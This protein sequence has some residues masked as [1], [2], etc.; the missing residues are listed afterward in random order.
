MTNQGEN[1]MYFKVYN[2]DPDKAAPLDQRS[3][4]SPSELLARIETLGRCTRWPG[5]R[6]KTSR[7]MGRKSASTS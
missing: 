5:S 6:P 3:K 7:S 2:I 4:I 1:K